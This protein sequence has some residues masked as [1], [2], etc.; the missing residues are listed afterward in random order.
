MGT[1]PVR[2]IVVPTA[3]AV[4]VTRLVW[5][6]GVL[7]LRLRAPGGVTVAALVGGSRHEV[8]AGRLDVHVSRPRQ[9]TL[10]ISRTGGGMSR[11]VLPLGSRPALQILNPG[12]G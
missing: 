8:G 2:R 1:A 4:R 7:E 10:E 5:H 3:P 12:H 11:L 9:V 6:A